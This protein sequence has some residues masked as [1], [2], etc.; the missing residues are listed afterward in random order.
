MTLASATPLLLG[1]PGFEDV[2]TPP[3]GLC[4][5]V[6]VNGS[7]PLT[8]TVLEMSP[9]DLKIQLDDDLAPGSMLELELSSLEFGFCTALRG[10]VHWRL[11]DADQPVAGVFLNSA[12]PHSVVGHYWAD[13][14]KELRYPCEW[15]CG[16]RCV[17]VGRRCDA[18]LLNYS[19]SGLMVEVHGRILEDDVLSLVDS[20]PLELAPIVAGT[21]RWRS[22]IGDQRCLL[23][24][25]LPDEQGQRLAAYL[26]S[27]GYFD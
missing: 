19:R 24:C 15:P 16:V 4:V 13:L 6:W 18:M 20:A 22:P 2:S 10:V 7:L 5:T 17:R 23:G 27:V 26:R 3:V 11:L 21:V 12:L 14:R 8:G 25:E 9:R 1:S